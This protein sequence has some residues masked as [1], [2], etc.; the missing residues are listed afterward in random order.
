MLE[1]SNFTKIKF[2]YRAIENNKHI[3]RV[4][5]DAKIC[6]SDYNNF[7]K[8][9]IKIIVKGYKRPMFELDTGETFESFIG[10]LNEY[11]EMLELSND[12]DK[13][14]VAYKSVERDV[15]GVFT[16]VESSTEDYDK[17]LNLCMEFLVHTYLYPVNFCK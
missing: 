1:Y 10:R 6:Y 8:V 4:Y 2:A 15:R 7:I 14:K 9:C 5:E 3:T 17:F 12:K 13:R 11:F 16:D